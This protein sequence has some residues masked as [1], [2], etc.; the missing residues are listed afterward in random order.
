MDVFNMR[1]IIWLRLGTA[2]RECKRYNLELCFLS[3]GASYTLC[4]SGL[5]SQL[6]NECIHNIQAVV[7]LEMRY[8]QLLPRTAKL[9]PHSPWIITLKKM[10][11]VSN[12]YFTIIQ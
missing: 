7:C 4:V 12:S 5:S 6:H 8:S 9:Q 11:G 1:F 10:T 3:A 2:L